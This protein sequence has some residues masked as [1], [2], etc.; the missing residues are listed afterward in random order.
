MTSPQNI[1]WYTFGMNKNTT[2]VIFSLIVILVIGGIV[3]AVRQTAVESK[4]LEPFAQ[5][6]N[7]SGAKFYGAFWCPHCNQQKALFGRAYKALPY[8][9]CSTPDGNSQTEI[10]ATENIES[11][12][13]W[14]FADGTTSNGVTSVK[15]L[16]ERTGCALPSEEATVTETTEVETA[17]SPEIEVKLT[18]DPKIEAFTPELE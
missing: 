12:P 9:E 10:C 3:F 7:D 17:E 2:A 15:D 8:V 1:F 4:A 13:T 18:E 11:Y 6:V 5:C 14:K 16:A